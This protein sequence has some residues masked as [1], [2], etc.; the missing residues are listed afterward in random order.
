MR[1][2]IQDANAG[3]NM[4]VA[5]T[6]KHAVRTATVAQQHGN[7]DQQRA[8]QI[9]Q[10]ASG[11]GQAIGSFMEGK[12]ATELEQRYS[13]A[14]HEQGVKTGMSEYQKDLKRSGFT[15]FIYGGQSPEYKGALNAS[16]RNASNAMY[17]EEAEFAEGEGAD[18]TPQQYQ[19]YIADKV[20]AYNKENFSDAHDAAFA[21]MQNWK[22]NSNELSRQ[23]YKN[24]QVR[25]Q[26]K[27]RQTVA[28]G[29]QTDFD[30]YKTMID[31]NPDKARQIGQDMFSG[32]YKP[33]GMSD[34]AYR[35][36]LISESLT[37]IRAHDYSAL[38][39]LN[40]SG[41]VSTF[42]AGEL[43]EY[44]TVRKIIDEDNFNHLEAARLNYETVVEDPRS[45][46]KDVR[47]AR[48]SMN[49]AIQQTAARNTGT[50]KHLKT[51]YG[52]DR[53][54]GVLDNQ[55]TKRVEDE[56]AARKKA[57]EEAVA[58][59]LKTISER[60]LR[61]ES[62]FDVRLAS[63]APSEKRDLMADRLDNL[64]IA[65]IDSSLDFAT[66]QK[67]DKQYVDLKAKLDKYDSKQETD[68]RKAEELA[69]KLEQ[70]EAEHA[71]G[72]KSLIDGEGYTSTDTK[73][74]QQHLD[75]AVTSVANQLIPDHN[76]S[77]ADK[78]S[79]IF[80]DPVLTSKFVRGTG[81]FSGYLDES[82]E[83][84][85]TIANLNA[86]LRAEQPD[87]H[88]SDEQT[89][90]ANSLEVI[91]HHAPQLYNKAFSREERVEIAYLQN[92]MK[93]KK[94]IAETVRSLDTLQQNVDRATA[95][96]ENA[97]TVMAIIGQSNAPSDIQ[98]DLYTEYQ[99]FLPLGHDAAIQAAREYSNMNVRAGGT[100]VRYGSTFEAVDGQNL[101][102]IMTKLGKTYRS[103]DTMKSGFSRVLG[104]VIGLGKEASGREL[105]NLRQ[106]PNVK[107][108]AFQG[109]LMFEQNGRVGYM[110]RSEIE[111]ELRGYDEWY[112]RS[113]SI[114]PR[115]NFFGY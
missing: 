13:K 17:V 83:V 95:Q 101:G 66:R 34:E 45:T 21:F 58:A 43:K 106:M 112:S 31:K 64:L 44:E 16:A 59:E 38:Q 11:L 73:V 27:A 63:A 76:I 85:R 54:R 29:F 65:R 18:M 56:I 35:E 109:G 69:T 97:E 37:A 70:E 62:D 7:Q 96:R 23:Q 48:A 104:N 55:W 26:Q 71:S 100:T 72:V 113:E 19:Q 41:L 33:V 98:D 15:E 75:G 1:S 42:N 110:S 57:N 25:E 10:A 67:L 61:N 102:D 39:L 78:L 46:A 99:T 50:T 88:F 68:D 103:G 60:V 8:Q 14:F 28:E 53:H 86:N 24:Y 12:R 92:A 105:Y 49:S 82:K 47:N 2:P 52:A 115:T 4:D 108:S 30:T 22:E 40:Q 9:N 79:T 5:P 3:A 77:N 114:R 84:Q 107:V 20:T 32:K 81:N 36:V 74:K 51:V 91:K 89:S 6:K 93:G 111:V 90:N 87:N 80:N 94:G